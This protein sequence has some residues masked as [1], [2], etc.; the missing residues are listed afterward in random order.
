MAQ[1][2]EANTGPGLDFY[3]SYA[4]QDRLWAE[5]V[6]G[7]L[8]S[9][10]YTIELDVWD[11]LPG[12]NII[13]AREDALQRA[14]RVLALCSAAY[15]GGGF[16]EQ[17]WTAVIA[18]ER[19][20]PHRLVP[21]WIEDL[22]GRQ[23]PGLL[24]SVQPI[25]LFG[26]S[27]AEASRRLIAGLAGELGPDGTPL[28]PGPAAPAEPDRDGSLGPRLPSSNR[29][30]AWHVPSRNPDFT[31][32]DS[33]L[34]RVREK[35]LRAFPGVVVLQGP[36]GV[37]KT[38]LSIEYAH[39]FASAYDAVWVVDSEQ[40]ELITGQFADLA[41]AIGAATPVADAQIAATAAIAALGD[42]R[43]WLLV[44]DN[45]EDPD[46]LTGFLP[47]GQGHVL[48]TTR[49][50]MWQEIG[51]LVAVDEF[52]RAEST[53]L[54][55]NRVATLPVVDADLVASVLGDLPLALAQAAGVLQT[56][57]PAAEFQRLLD[58]QATQLL[59]QG[60]PRSY[61]ATLAAATLIAMDKLAAAN[62]KAANL[63][64]L[65]G[66]LAPESIPATWF[67]RPA[68]YECLPGAA[69]VTPLPAEV[70][71]TI[72]V[73]GHIRDIGLGRVDQNGLRLHRLTQA[74]IR[75]H[76][77]EHQATY[78]DVV[79]AV[80]TAAAPQNSDDPVGWPDWSRLIPHLLVLAPENAPAA[81]RP[82]ACAAAR[83]LLVSGQAKAALAMTTRLH[84]IW[85]A[86]LGPDNTD[87]LTAA[88]HL[89]H[90]IHDIGG[91]AEAL[92]I[93]RD[94]YDRRLR[95]LGEDHPDT[96]RS[97]NDLAV[98]LGA[99]GRRE[100]ALMLERDTYDRYRRVLGEDHPDTLFSGGNLASSLH[101]LGRR[102]EALALQQ[103]SYDRHRRV[104][105]EDH[106]NTLT[107]ANNLAG[108]LHDLG[109]RKEALALQQ[110]T[111]DRCRRVLGE[112]HPNTL[113]FATNLAGTLR[114]LGRPKEALA[115]QQDTYDQR[116]RLLGEDHPDTL[117]SASN[118]AGTLRDLGRRKEA[119]ALQQD[120]YD[121]CRRV[122]GE[123]HPQ[124]LAFA[125]NLASILYSLAL[126]KAALAFHQDTYNRRC[127]VLGEDH[128][129]TLASARALAGNLEGLGLRKAAL[130]VKGQRPEDR[131]KGQKPRKRKKRK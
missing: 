19:G 72:H 131:V 98:S 89:A 34:V 35:L 32:R 24:R 117:N 65:C 90:A 28:F 17:D 50:G 63:L 42:G 113:F 59:S 58:S 62:P 75:D 83:Y 7:R 51:S 52:S 27:E 120:A 39:R 38:Q 104:L 30:A 18:A 125:G 47:D 123:D 56:G 118:L 115:L 68:A 100:E 60:K 97:A 3:I 23:L 86:E 37:G 15:F 128:P 33:L 96:L 101:D 78:R 71:E 106:P 105:G 111:Y 102:K 4:S 73:Y 88:Q 5:W 119:L 84:Q 61:A 16:P 99:L 91:Y 94:T 112:D 64:C 49:A 66:Y 29:P 48:V 95:L 116:R 41:V 130:R 2:K 69:E 107:S 67:S 109:R 126:R 14:D 87:T 129:D 110:D 36:G 13:L 44:F 53:A 74:I 76:T 31:G 122:L 40:P 11:W 20:K 10:G 93:Q 21:V 114:D 57:L 54:L 124:T 121:R 103:D 26:V 92:G 43:R 9:A 8:I 25:K 70:L 80:L 12:D 85:I 55:T 1:S 82:L 79:I 77:A 6:G 46:H 22:E 45:V 81:L 127:R 108:T